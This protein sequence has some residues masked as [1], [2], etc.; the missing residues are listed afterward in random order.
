MSVLCL[1][2][3]HQR[4]PMGLT[5]LVA[6][7]QGRDDEPRTRVVLVPAEALPY[8]VLDRM[9]G[10]V[11]ARRSEDIIGQRHP[12]GLLDQGLVEGKTCRPMPRAAACHE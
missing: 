7:P 6:V 9:D 3:L 10:A 2:T 11:E 1:P 8:Q 4:L 5:D 12:H